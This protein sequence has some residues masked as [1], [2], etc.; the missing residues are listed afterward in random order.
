MRV[1]QRIGRIDRVGQQA[2]RISVVNFKVRNTVEERLYDRLH[3]KLLLFA[4]SLGDLEAVIGQEIQQL[5]VELL[6]KDLT[7]EEEQKLIDQSERAIQNNLI[8]IQALEESGDALIAFSDYVQRKI[9]EGREKGRYIQPR[10]LEDYLTD[11]FEREYQG[12][13]I[14]FNTPTNG[15]LRIRLS[16]EAHFSLSDFIGSNRTLSARPFHQR[17]FS[18][19][20][21]REIAQRLTFHQR[22]TV[23]FVNHLSPLIQWITKI[24]K[25][26]AHSFFDLSAVLISH[27][28]LSIGD[29]CYII[30]RWKLT[31]LH[32]RE[33]LAYGICSLASGRDYL[34]EESEAIV[35]HLLR[36]GRD[37]D[38]ADYDRETL[39]SVHEALEKTLENRFSS[40]VEEFI[41][42]NDTIYQIKTQRVNAIFDRRIAE[43][44]Q[45]LETLREKDSSDRMIR[46]A[47]GLL[48]AAMENKEK[49]LRELG[50][51]AHTHVEADPVAAGIFRVIGTQA[52]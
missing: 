20:F 23:H 37:W 42:E 51:K 48:R 33:R 34:P 14:N 38:Y 28:D 17:E 50:E 44:R 52:M 7:P 1:E 30:E 35:Q 9:E 16:N 2:K 29:Y 3:V 11:F 27:N 6:S 46:L 10:E 4:N 32:T 31:G 49:R 39:Y 5:T 41:A 22:S 18:I 21:R 26:R 47:E 36:Y 45:R 24:N 8:Q 15:C 40:T 25:E 12:C 19:T 13:E 43:H